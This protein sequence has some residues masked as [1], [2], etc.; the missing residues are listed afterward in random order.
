MAYNPT[1]E[2][3]DVI[4]VIHNTQS[5]FMVDVC[6][7]VLFNVEHTITARPVLS[8]RRQIGPKRVRQPSIQRSVQLPIERPHDK[9][10]QLKTIHQQPTGHEQIEQQKLKWQKFF[11]HFLVKN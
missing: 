2:P 7:I 4:F 11:Y 3:I 9:R 8:Q 10:Q 6:E 5:M 1:H